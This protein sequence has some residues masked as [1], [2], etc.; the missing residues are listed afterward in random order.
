MA[1]LWWSLQENGMDC[2]FVSAE[3]ALMV[4]QECKFLPQV[5]GVLVKDAASGSRNMRREKRE[6]SCR[7]YSRQDEQRNHASTRQ[8][9]AR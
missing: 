1:A 3:A 2:F 4:A 5:G 6:I 8:D 7:S 9:N